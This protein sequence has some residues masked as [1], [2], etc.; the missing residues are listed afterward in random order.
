MPVVHG[1]KLCCAQIAYCCEHVGVRRATTGQGKG[2]SERDELEPRNDFRTGLRADLTQGTGLRADL[3]QE[4]MIA[5][6]PKMF[7]HA[8]Q[9]PR[10]L[11]LPWR[12]DCLATQ[13]SWPFLSQTVVL[14]VHHAASGA[15]LIRNVVAA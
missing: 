2:I 5:T 9:L 7:K 10:R 3:T 15:D 12:F 6:S 14:Q 8:N 4:I 11:H 13:A 1:E